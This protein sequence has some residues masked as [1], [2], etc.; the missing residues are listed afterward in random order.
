MLDPK[1]TTNCLMMIGWGVSHEEA[2][3]L[4]Q[5]LTDKVATLIIRPQDQADIVA[6]PGLRALWLNRLGTQVVLELGKNSQE[7]TRLIGEMRRVAGEGRTRPKFFYEWYLAT[8]LDTLRH[9]CGDAQDNR[10]EGAVLDRLPIWRECFEE[11]SWVGEVSLNDHIAV[12]GRLVPLEAKLLQ[13]RGEWTA[14]RELLVWLQKLADGQAPADLKPSFPWEQFQARARIAMARLHLAQGRRN[15][16]QQSLSEALDRLSR[17]LT[18]PATAQA[19]YEDWFDARLTIVESRGPDVPFEILHRELLDLHPHCP[20]QN[21]SRNRYARKLFE[22][23]LRAGQTTAARKALTII[24]DER[25]PDPEVGEECTGENLR[26]C[27]ESILEA[28]DSPAI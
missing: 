26:K 25:R 16:A 10:D 19:A 8:R 12:A 7:T 22:T 27:L 2:Q 6:E 3:R 23:A 13:R 9:W 14:A 17:W 11:I 4:A 5:D 1:L 18:D 20:N 21:R 24:Q 15:D 28:A